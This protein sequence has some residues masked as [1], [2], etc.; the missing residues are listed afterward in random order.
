MKSIYICMIETKK[1]SKIFSEFPAKLLKKSHLHI[2]IYISV[3]FV[4]FF[5]VNYFYFFEKF[6]IINWN[7]KLGEMTT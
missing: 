5:A 3:E 6:S 4:C 2:Y 7:A 1:I